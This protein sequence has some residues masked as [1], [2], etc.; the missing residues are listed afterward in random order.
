MMKKNRAMTFVELLVVMAL[1]SSISIILFNNVKTITIVHRNVTGESIS[2]T[3]INSIFGIVSQKDSN[4]MKP[5]A[6]FNKTSNEIKSYIDPVEINGL[7]INSSELKKGDNYNDEQVNEGDILWSKLIT[8]NVYPRFIIEND[9]LYDNSDSQTKMLLGNN[10][11]KAQMFSF[12]VENDLTPKNYEVGK[13]NYSNTKME[14]VKKWLLFFSTT[15]KMANN[16]EKKI[17]IV[18]NSESKYPRV[19]HFKDSSVWNDF[20]GWFWGWFWYVFGWFWWYPGHH[21]CY[22]WWC[23]WW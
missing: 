15:Q 9:K 12:Y 23:G 11:R 19:F 20:W 4:L 1:L 21:H 22:G 5:K 14:N 17:P 16:K 10:F 13:T 18:S 3:N 7:E 6:F 8:D 2:Y